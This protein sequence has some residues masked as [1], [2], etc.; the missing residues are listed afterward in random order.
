MHRFLRRLGK[1]LAALLAVLLAYLLAAFTLGSIVLTP[2]RHGRRDITLYLLDNGVHT[3]LALP[4]ANDTYDWTTF[5]RPEDA[6]DT[7]FAPAYVA[8]GW[9]DR[10]FYLE[11][12]HWRDLKAT[13]AWN[14]ISGQGATI[15]HVTFLPPLRATAHS[16]AIPVSRDE[17]RALV[18]SIRDSFRRSDDGRAI[19]IGGRA[20][21]DH[22]AFYE[23][24]GSYSLFT[25]C[26][27][28]TNA[29]LKAAGLTHVLWT[30]FS[31][32]LMRAYR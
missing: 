8:F 15:I 11:T 22:D 9:G 24:R 25:T 29:R 19:A 16:I 6:R 10:A 18:A 23:A 13:T 31:G 27:T 14:A 12:P 2:E 26:N 17:Y 5:I 30:P 7:A 32:S 21:G 28:W 4:L 20:Y 1:T 3:D